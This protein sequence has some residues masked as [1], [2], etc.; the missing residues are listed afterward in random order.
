[1][2]SNMTPDIGQLAADTITRMR[3]AGFDAAQV[4]VGLS[5]QDELNVAHN[6]P[7]LLRSTEDQSMALT[8][9]VDGRKASTTLTDLDEVSVARAVASLMETAHT[10]PQDDGNAVSAGQSGHFE[11]GPVDGDREIL[12]A[13]VEEILAF[14]AERTP[15][16]NIEEGA[17]LHRVSRGRTLTS[18]GSDLTWTVGSYGLDVMGTASEEGRSS[19]LNGAGGRAND[20]AGVHACDL[21]GI[22]EMLIE[23]ERQID[24]RQI[25]ANFTGDVVLAPGAVTDLLG[26]LLQQ[27]QDG[28]LLSNS[29]LYRERVGELIAAPALTVTSRFD[30]PGCTPFSHDAFRTEPI[31]VVK[32]GRLGM[33]LPSLYGSR[34]TGVSHVPS[35]TGWRVLTGAT[36]RDELIAGVARGALVSHLSMGSPGPNGD[37]SGVIKSSFLIEDG[38]VG[39]ALSE[40]MIS[41][42]MA[43]MLKDISGISAEHLDTGSLDLPW[44]RIPGLHFS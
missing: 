40:T 28:A 8:G 17:A 30:A 32:A 4:D 39:Q 41:G 15:L 24:T 22:G 42:N 38:T 18:E 16:M 33:L 9:I 37:F 43:Q 5:V 27:L 2:P 11:Q 6:S 21:F 44:I 14:R 20:V 13:K 25:D 7:S 23:T 1:M 3:E 34:R 10:S 31:E 35:S 12:A 29:S 19:S 36:P 26:W